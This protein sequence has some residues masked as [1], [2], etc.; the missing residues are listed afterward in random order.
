VNL[1]KLNEQIMAALGN[2]SLKE[3][4]KEVSVLVGRY[5]EEIRT[6]RT[7]NAALA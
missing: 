2:V 7:M 5:E 4:S 1:K 3:K 6:L